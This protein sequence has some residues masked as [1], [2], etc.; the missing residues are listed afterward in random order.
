METLNKLFLKT[1]YLTK[2]ISAPL[3][4]VE[5]IQQVLVPEC[6]LR[7][8]QQDLNLDDMTQVKK[9]MIESTEYGSIIYN[10]V[11]K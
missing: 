4:P 5:L 7:L 10:K 9:V 2:T 3:T 11:K 8:I 1:N 6:G